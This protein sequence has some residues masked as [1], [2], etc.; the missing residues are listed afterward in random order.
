MS[1]IF[2]CDDF[3]NEF[4]YIN[5]LDSN[6]LITHGCALC[7][8]EYGICEDAAA[9]LASPDEPFIDCI[10]FSDIDTNS[11]PVSCVI[12]WYGEE[13]LETIGE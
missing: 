6:G 3:E 2:N 7:M 13:Y 9:K 5:Y 8:V 11:F 12:G 4:E 1:L 10:P